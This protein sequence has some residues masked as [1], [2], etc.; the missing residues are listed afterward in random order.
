L[1]LALLKETKSEPLQKEPNCERKFTNWIELNWFSSAREPYHS[2]V[3]LN[4]SVEFFYDRPIDTN[5]LKSA[6]KI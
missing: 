1:I 3:R 5:L 4:A 2:L 6:L